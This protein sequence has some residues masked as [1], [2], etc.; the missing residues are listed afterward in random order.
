MWYKKNNNNKGG[1][2]TSIVHIVLSGTID[3]IIK[4]ALLR[5]ETLS[6]AN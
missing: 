6:F 1:D 3:D 2:F 4:T 5:G